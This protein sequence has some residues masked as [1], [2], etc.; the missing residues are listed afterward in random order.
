MCSLGPWRCTVDVGVGRGGEEEEQTCSEA[1]ICA[2]H[3][4]EDSRVLV[5]LVPD[6]KFKKSKIVGKTL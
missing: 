6:E 4:G 1:T 2:G 5:M 3:L